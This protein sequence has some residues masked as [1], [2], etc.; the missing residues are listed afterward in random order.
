MKDILALRAALR[1]ATKL[2]NEG[3]W[4]RIEFPHPQGV[5]LKYGAILSNDEHEQAIGTTIFTSTPKG[6]ITSDFVHP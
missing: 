5:E 2:T 1:R 3:Y 6:I 4:V